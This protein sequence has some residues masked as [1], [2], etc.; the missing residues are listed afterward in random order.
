MNSHGSLH[1]SLTEIRRLDGNN[2]FG[3]VHYLHPLISDQSLLCWLT[4]RIWSIIRT[5]RC[6]ESTLYTTIA[7]QR[8]PTACLPNYM[9]IIMTN[10]RLM[11]SSLSLQLCSN[12]LSCTTGWWDDE[13]GRTCP[14]EKVHSTMREGMYLSNQ[15]CLMQQQPP[16]L[17]HHAVTDAGPSCSRHRQGDR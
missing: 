16:P 12:L 7:V 9:S 14:Y 13:E 15:R 5:I 2:A 3:H 10:C 11:C 8:F 4:R 1:F 17:H 6:M